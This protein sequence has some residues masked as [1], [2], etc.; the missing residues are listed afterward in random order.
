MTLLQR[1]LL[2]VALAF[3]SACSAN[4]ASSPSPNQP[5]TAP[6]ANSGE[7]ASPKAEAVCGGLAGFACAAGTYCAFELEAHCGAADQTG[8]C[9]AIPE[10]CTDEQAPV[11]GCNDVTY[12]NSCEAARAGVSFG[13]TGECAVPAPATPARRPATP[14][15]SS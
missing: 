10:R 4:P 5:A 1:P 15:T 12:P 14:T 9:K 3:C 13:A 8:V 2:F 7:P 6:P 11:C